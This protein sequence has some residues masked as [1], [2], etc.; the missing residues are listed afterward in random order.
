MSSDF[1]NPEGMINPQ[2]P[3][4]SQIFYA[5]TLAGAISSIAGTLV[6]HPLDTIKVRMQ[7]EKRSKVSARQIAYKALVREG[8]LSLYKGVFQPLWGATS[9][10]IVTFAGT[11]TTKY[12][13]HRH[14]PDLNRIP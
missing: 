1:A 6:G 14:F 8:S 5:S 13:L 12:N 9:I 2:S 4:F 3:S 7:L 11:E 10:H